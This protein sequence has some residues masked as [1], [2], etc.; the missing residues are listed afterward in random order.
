[1]DQEFIQR[2]E[3]AIVI[4][5]QA[6]GQYASRTRNMIAQYGHVSAL[7]RLMVSA[8][9][10]QGFRVLRDRNQLDQTFEAIVVAYPHLFDKDAVEAAEWR[11]ANPHSLL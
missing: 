11:L 1:M 2:I 3:G 6:I 8:D 10:Q 7:S 4:Y 5:E 9:L